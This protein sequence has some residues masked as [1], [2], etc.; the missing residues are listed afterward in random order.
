MSAKAQMLKS[1]GQE[2]PQNTKT[3]SRISQPSQRSPL[4]DFVPSWWKSPPG[5]MWWFR[6]HRAHD[7][8]RKFSWHALID[9]L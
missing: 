2:Q 3:R 1:Y 7:H 4:R 5:W 8:R 6:L 9:Q